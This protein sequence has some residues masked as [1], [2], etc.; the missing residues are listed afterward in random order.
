M[1]LNF[2][3]LFIFFLFYF[4]LTLTLFGIIVFVS[5]WCCPVFHVGVYVPVV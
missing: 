1:L 3:I 4:Y 2:I 5:V